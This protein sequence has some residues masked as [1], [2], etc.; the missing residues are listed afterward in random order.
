MKEVVMPTKSSGEIK[1]RII[2]NTQKNGDIYVLE[3]KIVY[4][5]NKKQDKILSTKLLSKIPKGTEFP[6]P[7]RPKLS[8]CSKEPE[9]PGKI[10]ASREHIGMTELIAHI[11]TASGIDDGIYSNTDLGT[12]QKI[13]SIARYLL[14]TNGQSLPGILTWQFNHP[15]PYEDGISE[16]IYHELF[17]K[18][19][20][21]ESLQQ[22]F[23]A[24]RCAR[25]EGR[26]VLAY[27][28]TSIS[29]Y[30]EHQIEAR[31][32]F[33]KDEDGLKT[34]KLLTLYSVE[35]RQPVAFTKQPGNLPDVI[36]I[37]NALKQLSVLG[38]GDA[39]IITDNGYYSEHNL[40]SL[41][42]AHFDFV[43]LVKTSLK[44]VK[45]EIDAH[46]NDFGSISSVCP[47]DTGTHG[48]TLTLMRDF[49]KVRKYAD[50]ERGVQ[51]GD[52]EVFR[53]RVYLHLYFNP[54]RRVE[55]NVSFDDNL[56]ELR[57]NIEEGINVEDLPISSQNKAAKYLH[58]KR[59][60]KT[61]HVSFKE[62]A[63]QDAKK[64][65]G[66]FALVSNCEK[67]TFEC[68][69]KYRKRETIESFFESM[70]QRADGTRLRVWD[71]DTLRGRLFVQ[72]VALCYYEYLSNEIRNMKKLLGVKN[73]E[74]THDTT[75]NLS[76]EKKLKNWLD[77]SPIYLVLQWFDT[78]EAVKV[79]SKLLSKRW[80]TEITLRDKMFL[81]KIGVALPY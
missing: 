8:C 5:S 77:N 49:F 28:S 13:L 48:I 9:S 7:T 54:A 79:S 58:I 50:R 15:L 72:F 19:G 22:S 38:L 73:G 33:N 52:E 29:T 2:H 46:L 34:I 59:W 6:V 37:E 36:T 27:D 80:T 44:W 18:I 20:R 1:T 81:E 31:Y 56:I 11:G 14:A 78:V 12:A 68:L 39:E 53:R 67:D 3:R 60:G 64:Y 32:G 10:T 61:I 66:Y 45:A 17:V 21:D 41:F 23:F 35:T 51:K 25:I 75:A 65:H 47:F 24:S 42:L 71:T 74:P 69:R 57:R 63:C 43:T 16:D 70:K 30:S 76:L 55:E 26:A 40:A 4:D 62:A